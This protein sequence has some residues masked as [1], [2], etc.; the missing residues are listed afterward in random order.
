MV[1]MPEGGGSNRPRLKL[2]CSAKE[3]DDEEERKRRIWVKD[4]GDLY[5][6]TFLSSQPAW[7]R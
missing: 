4:I 3:E 5:K 2:G 7:L 6:H 1:E